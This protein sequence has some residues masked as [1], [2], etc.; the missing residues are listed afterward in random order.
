MSIC[1]DVFSMNAPSAVRP[2]HD[3]LWE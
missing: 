3:I 2:S 1:S